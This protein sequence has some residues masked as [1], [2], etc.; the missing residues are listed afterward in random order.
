MAR[1]QNFSKL[2]KQRG[3][4]QSQRGSRI[5]NASPLENDS[6]SITEAL[7]P[8]T[9]RG[10]FAISRIAVKTGDIGG[11]TGGRERHDAGRTRSP[12]KRTRLFTCGSQDDGCHQRHTRPLPTPL[13]SSSDQHIRIQDICALLNGSED[14][15]EDDPIFSESELVP[16]RLHQA[17]ILR[18]RLQAC[19][20]SAES[21]DV[22]GS[23]ESII[24][25]ATDVGNRLAPHLS[26]ANLQDVNA[27]FPRGR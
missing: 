15:S 21:L 20:L 11:S 3:L 26:F 14:D 19:R 7:A 9:S 17:R 1:H 10:G 2:P 22:V 23:D 12:R 18:N 4:H 24:H 8:S 5:A 13:G 6:R 27:F 25:L 16:D